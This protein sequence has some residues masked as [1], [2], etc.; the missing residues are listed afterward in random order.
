MLYSV[1]AKPKAAELP[2]FWTLLNDG[3]IG[4]QEPDGREI[5]ACMKRAVLTED[6]V[7]WSETCYCTPPLNHEKS[8][9]YDQFFSDI[10]IQPQ[11]GPTSLT[12]ERFW[13]YLQG[14]FNE[15]AKTGSGRTLSPGL[16]H[17]PLRLL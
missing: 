6:M 8:T 4:R 9:V 7:E 13:R 14:R 3:T 2:R 11:T 5:V 15:T 17:V 1:R 12:G 16:K 10:E